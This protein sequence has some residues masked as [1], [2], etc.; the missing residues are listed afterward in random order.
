M[1][2][3]TR[4]DISLANTNFDPTSNI[5]TTFLSNGNVGIGTSSPG[6][7]LEVN[8]TLKITDGSQGAG[9]ILVSDSTGLASWLSAV[10]SL[11][12]SVWTLS[13]N[14]VGSSDFIGSTNVQDLVLKTNNT[15]RMRILSAVSST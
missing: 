1:N 11:S 6:A 14:T 5:I 13:G 8:G 9:K 2:S 7:K 15:E 10:S 3:R 12:G 4:L